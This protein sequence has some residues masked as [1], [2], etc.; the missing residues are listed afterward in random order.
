MTAT[1]A[2]QERAGQ[3]PRTVFP[4]AGRPELLDCTLRDGAYEIGFSFTVRDT[5][6][7]STEL[8]R[9]AVRWIEVADGMGLGG[10]RVRGEK[11]GPTDAEHVAAAVHAAPS[12]RIGVIAVPE[13][14][15]PADISAAVD[16]GACFARIGVDITASQ[17]AE[18]LI[19]HARSAGLLVSFNAMKSYAVPRDELVR[20]SLRA[21]RA[22]AQLCY[23]VDSAGTLLPREVQA[24]I[25]AL[26]DAGV[27]SGFHGHDNLALAVANSLA[28]L[29]SG[30]VIVDCCLHGLGRGAGNA[31]T[32][33]LAT[34]SGR[35]GL[36]TLYDAGLL[37]QT[38][39]RHIRPRRD[40]PRGLDA[41]DL[42][43]GDAQFHSGALPR[44]DAI[45]RRSGVPLLELIRQ[46]G[47]A[48]PIAPSN[49]L[50]EQIASR[51][52]EEPEIR[53]SAPP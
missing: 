33:V 14:A 42:V 41:L 7:I 6:A 18:P 20:R 19:E 38:A 10:R 11:S 45:A 4:E 32:E 49:D 22:G 1:D 26:G 2:A 27:P 5:A 28:A 34:L 48:D 21:M 51:M 35:L 12:A 43:M 16:A 3:S 31:Q 15:T 24:T 9:A 37:A 17:S 46:V 53:L 39:E 50:I 29:E 47:R 25:R 13:I 52:R 30:A 8:S 44:V 40:R 36:P 23:V